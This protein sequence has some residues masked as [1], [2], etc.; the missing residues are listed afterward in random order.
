MANQH[1]CVL[2]FSSCVVEGF[3]LES[4]GK[5]CKHRNLKETCEVCHAPFSMR[6]I[7]WEDRVNKQSS[8]RDILT[9][10]NSRQSSP[11]SKTIRRTDYLH[12]QYG[13]SSES[14]V[15]SV[16]SWKPGRGSRTPSVGSAASG[17]N[18]DSFLTHSA[19]YHN[20]QQSQY[21]AVRM[22]RMMRD[23]REGRS[24]SSDP[25]GGDF[26]LMNIR[27]SKALPMIGGGKTA[28]SNRR[29]ERRK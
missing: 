27:A 13:S 16:D 1:L 28:T 7:S 15:D 29:K 20:N 3:K 25:V 26:C 23:A 17:P 21:Q 9:T 8:R 12:R 24:S 5:N 14:S 4:V 6:V 11:S 10:G 18:I 19:R 22:L 2:T